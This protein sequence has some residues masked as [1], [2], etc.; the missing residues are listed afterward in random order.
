MNI[1][2]IFC[3]LLLKIQIVS[4]EKPHIQKF[5]INSTENSK[6]FIDS[7][8]KHTNSNISKNY[9]DFINHTNERITNK[10]LKK[11]SNIIYH[12]YNLIYFTQTINN[13]NKIIINNTNEEINF[14]NSEKIIKN[15]QTN[16]FKKMKKLIRY[17]IYLAIFL[18]F[19]KTKINDTNMKK[20]KK[21][22]KVN[23]GKNFVE[24]NKNKIPYFN[25]FI[26]SKVKPNSIIII[27]AYILSLNIIIAK[28]ST[29]NNIIYSYD[30]YIIY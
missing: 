3:L 29:K 16:K 15:F 20:A 28:I 13:I 18:N 2:L 14:L 9:D 4:S 12:I 5:I 6:S 24:L 27:I 21:K 22:Y 25:I 26:F 7:S 17:L 1:L 11:E 19:I 8:D 30:N 23:L 10:F